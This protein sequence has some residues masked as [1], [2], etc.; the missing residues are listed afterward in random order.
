MKKFKKSIESFKKTTEL[1]PDSS[2]ALN[3]LAYLYSELGIH[4][5]DGLKLAKRAIAMQPDNSAY[6]DTMGWLHYKLGNFKEA[7]KYLK[8]AAEL[9]PDSAETQ[10]HLSQAY[11]KI[12]RNG[13]IGQIFAQVNEVKFEGD[14]IVENSNNKNLGFMILMNLS[15]EARDKYLAMPDVPKNRKL[16]G[17]L[18]STNFSCA[19]YWR[20]NI[21]PEICFRTPEFPRKRPRFG[22]K[23][24]T[25]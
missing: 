14:A 23:R 8:Q 22:C 5:E 7:V 2:L 12:W 10:Y 20:F 17:L 18:R 15:Q 24:D 16:K 4:L 6:L 9:D 11:L 1:D 3:N 13:S 21:S 25:S 19:K